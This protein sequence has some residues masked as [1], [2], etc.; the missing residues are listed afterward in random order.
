MLSVT[1]KKHLVVLSSASES[2]SCPK[3]NVS[4]V[5]RT[6]YFQFI[7]Y[8]IVPCYFISFTSVKGTVRQ[9][10]LPISHQ[11]AFYFFFFVIVVV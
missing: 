2:Y 4:Q 7:R 8:S 9:A 1:Q 11:K 6:I 10:E 5:L 3:K